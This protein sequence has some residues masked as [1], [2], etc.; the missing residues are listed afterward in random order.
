MALGPGE[1]LFERLGIDDRRGL[2]LCRHGLLAPEAGQGSCPGAC[3][4]ESI[5]N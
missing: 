3:A 4:S 2:D 5:E 1:E